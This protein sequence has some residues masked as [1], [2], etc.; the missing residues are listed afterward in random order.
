MYKYSKVFIATIISRVVI[1]AAGLTIGL[2]VGMI[3]PAVLV[4][5]GVAIA[6]VS[7]GAFVARR[8]LG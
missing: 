8:C 7:G 5:A 3:S 1:A 4:E 2:C 6:L